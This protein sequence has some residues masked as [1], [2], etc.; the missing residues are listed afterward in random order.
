METMF[1]GNFFVNISSLTM[2]I[3]VTLVALV[4][5]ALRSTF[6]LA[7]TNCLLFP[8]LNMATGICNNI[9]RS[10]STLCYMLD[11]DSSR[12]KKWRI[13]QSYLRHLLVQNGHS[14]PE[15][16]ETFVEGV[17]KTSRNNVWFWTC[18]YQHLHGNP[19]NGLFNIH[20]AAKLQVN[21]RKLKQKV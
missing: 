11:W 13:F 17:S 10:I 6:I 21:Q 15:I 14:K 3:V 2:Q 12:D 5:V 9:W 19:E 16:V 7:Y 18:Q 1:R 20:D 8:D 4:S